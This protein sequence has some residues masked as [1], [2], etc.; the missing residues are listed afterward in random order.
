VI[1]FVLQKN[2]FPAGQTDLSTAEADLKGIKVLEKKPWL[3]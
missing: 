2:G 1:A 3:D